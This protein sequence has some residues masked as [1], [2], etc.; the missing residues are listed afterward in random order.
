M[1]VQNDTATTENNTVVYQ[2]IKNRAA[3][4]PALPLQLTGIY[5]KEFRTGSL[6]DIY[7]SIFIAALFAIARSGEQPN[8]HR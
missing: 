5:R 6:T 1:G 2:N 8:V 3:I 7:T 4:Y